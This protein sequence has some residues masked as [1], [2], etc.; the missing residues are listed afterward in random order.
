MLRTAA[1]AVLL[2]VCGCT[3]ARYVMTDQYGGVVAIPNNSNSWPSYNRKHAEE[4][5]ARQCPQGYVIEQE[6]VVVADH[7][8]KTLAEVNQEKVAYRGLGGGS[9]PAPP[10]FPR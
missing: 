1:L 10:R 4:L 2:A 6:G 5:M 3:Q 7:Q 9:A 8:T